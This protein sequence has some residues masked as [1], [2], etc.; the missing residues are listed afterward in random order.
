MCRLK[1]GTFCYNDWQPG[2]ILRDMAATAE[3]GA[4]HLRLV[5]VWPWFQPMPADVSRLYLDRLD[6]LMRAAAELGI[7]VMPTF[8]LAG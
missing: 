1:A 4:D 5:V 8:I 3:V 6:D 2:R 7:V